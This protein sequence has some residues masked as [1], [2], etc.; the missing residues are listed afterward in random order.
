MESWS[1]EYTLNAV[2]KIVTKLS[3]LLLQS[4]RTFLVWHE[5]GFIIENDLSLAMKARLLLRNVNVVRVNNDLRKLLQ[6]SSIR[7]RLVIV[8]IYN[9]TETGAV[10]PLGDGLHFGEPFSRILVNIDFSLPETADLWQESR[11]LPSMLSTGHDQAASSGR[12][13]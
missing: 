13:Q 4:P 10:V 8:P 6:T 9:F 7:E 12:A 3:I 5:V 1:A 11:A 2:K